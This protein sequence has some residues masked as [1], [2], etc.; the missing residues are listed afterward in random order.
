MWRELPD[1]RFVLEGIS[2][3][4]QAR[5]RTLLG[6]LDA[7]AAWLQRHWLLLVTV[8]LGASR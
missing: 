7:V 6:S 2:P 8:F 5:N 4:R 1:G 3:R